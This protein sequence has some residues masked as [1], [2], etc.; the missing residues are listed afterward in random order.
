MTESLFDDMC[1]IVRR[2]VEGFKSGMENDMKV[3]CFSCLEEKSPSEMPAIND[4]ICR[5]CIKNTPYC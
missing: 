5:E 3:I 2:Q 1:D 4:A